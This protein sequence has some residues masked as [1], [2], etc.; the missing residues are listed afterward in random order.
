M[1]IVNMMKIH[2]YDNDGGE[3]GRRAHKA[4][5]INNIIIII[6]IRWLVGWLTAIHLS[7]TTVARMLGAA[8]A[9]AS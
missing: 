5:I 1:N 7:A 8:P 3:W 9:T 6:V 4:I 2:T